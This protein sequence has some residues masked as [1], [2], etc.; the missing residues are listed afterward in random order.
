MYRP[1][2]KQALFQ[3]AWGEWPGGKKIIFIQASWKIAHKMDNLIFDLQY[4]YHV[5]CAGRVSASV[6]SIYDVPRFG[7]GG[8][9][10]NLY[11]M[12]FHLY[13]F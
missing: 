1:R 12:P 11:F 6:C 8:T 5:M 3:S 10:P 4:Q 9:F 2:A 13:I 7:A